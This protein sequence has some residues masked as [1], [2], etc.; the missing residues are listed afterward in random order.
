LLYPNIKDTITGGRDIK[1]RMQLQSAHLELLIKFLLMDCPK[2]LKL[3]QKRQIISGQ[4][5]YGSK[6]KSSRNIWLKKCGFTSPLENRPINKRDRVKNI[7]N[8]H[9]VDRRDILIR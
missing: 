1:H 8:Y 7:Y 2:Y 4:S 5:T 3:K 9:D 6:I